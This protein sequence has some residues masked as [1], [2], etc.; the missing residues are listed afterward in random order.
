M[1]TETVSNHCVPLKDLYFRFF[2]DAFLVFVHWL[3]KSFHFLCVFAL[4]PLLFPPFATLLVAQALAL[5]LP[6]PPFFF[7]FLSESLNNDQAGFHHVVEHVEAP[8][9]W[10]DYLLV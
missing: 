1:S 4:P 10:M 6:P 9:S 2:F 3:L 8:V 7:P 5:K